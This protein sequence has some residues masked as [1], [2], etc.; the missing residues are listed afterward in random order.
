MAYD[1]D[2]DEGNSKQVHTPKFLAPLFKPVSLDGNLQSTNVR[3]DNVHDLASP[4]TQL[5]TQ[6]PSNVIITDIEE[7]NMSSKS[8]Q[9]ELLLW[10]Y[11]MG[12]CS[13][14]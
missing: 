1:K 2:K 10:Y 8:P 9:A 11:Y 3:E 5:P 14:L 13:F 6:P 12:H 7:D 4:G